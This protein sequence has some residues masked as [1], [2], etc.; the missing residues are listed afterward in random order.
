MSRRSHIFIDVRDSSIAANVERPA[1]REWLI[2]VDNAVSRRDRFGWIA[3]KRIVHAK[4]LRE[5]LI[6]LWLVHADGEVRDIEG[7]ELI[8]TLTE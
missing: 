1:G 7:A 3:E 8:P 6:R 2:R 4:R 5:F